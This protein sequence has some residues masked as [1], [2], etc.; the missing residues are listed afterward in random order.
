MR[1]AIW[2][3]RA[4]FEPRPTARHVPKSH[5]DRALRIEHTIEMPRARAAQNRRGLIH[6]R[7][8]TMGAPSFSPYQ[9]V[10][11]ATVVAFPGVLGVSPG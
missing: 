4:G 3:I 9:I 11:F 5:A 10:A 2:L 1:F 7:S 6:L 8:N